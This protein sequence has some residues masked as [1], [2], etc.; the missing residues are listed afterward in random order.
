MLYFLNK[1]QELLTASLLLLF[2][3]TW[4]SKANLPRTLLPPLKKIKLCLQ[5][6]LCRYKSWFEILSYSRALIELKK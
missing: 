6:S 2:N 4:G 1:L 5:N 3:A